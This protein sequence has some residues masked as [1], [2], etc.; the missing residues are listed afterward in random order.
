MRATTMG[1][2]VSLPRPSHVIAIR[3]EP[4]GVGVDV[5]VE[6][7]P[8]GVGHDR[9][10]RNVCDARRYADRLSKATGWPVVDH[11]GGA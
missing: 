10:H 2:V 9:E 7:P 11:V 8:T 6:P 4:F 5:M 3:P 1:E